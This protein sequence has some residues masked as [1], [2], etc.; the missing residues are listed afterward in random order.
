MSLRLDDCT[1]TGPAL[2]PQFVQFE[3]EKILV[4]RNLLPKTTGADGEQL[5]ARWESF[6]RKLRDLT[7]LGGSIRVQNHVIE[8][9]Q[10]RLGYSKI[11]R[12]PE[13]V[14]TSLK[15]PEDGGSVLVDDTTSTRLRF[16]S[17]EFESDIESP[18]RKNDAYRYS[19]LQVAK[20]VL[21]AAGQRYALLTN[22]IELRLV[23]DD[24]ARRESQ[25]I[26]DLDEWRKQRDVP[27]SYRLLIALVSPAG[28]KFLPDLIE[29][30]RLQQSRVTKELRLQARQA[31]EQFIQEVL[32][33]PENRAY[34]ERIEDKAEL[35]KKLW[36]EGLILVYRL[37]FILKS[38]SNDN[39]AKQFRFAASRIWR[40]TYSPAIALANWVTP[41]LNGEETGE[42][43]ETGLRQLF[44]MFVEGIES[45]ELNVKPLGGAL[46][47]ED[48]TP[49]LSHRKWGER[50][51]ALL[52]RNLM[53]APR[54]KS[55]DALQRVHYG[56][57]DVEE[58]GRVYEALLEL[59]P[60]IAQESMC[61]LRRQKLEVVV[62][63]AQGEKYRAVVAAVGTTDETDN[64]DE[65]AEDAEEETGSRKK[66]KVEW[67]EQIPAGQFYLRVGIGRKASGS[68]YTPH[69]FV[70]FLVKETLTPLIAERS[71][72]SDPHPAELLKL[73]ILDPAMGSGHFLVE[74]CRFLGTA[75]Y[76]AVRTCDERAARAE[77][78]AETRADRD[79]RDR[80]RQEVLEYRS[81]IEALPIDSD[82]LMQYLPS[83]SPT[84][85]ETDVAPKKAI[86][87][88]M[89]LVAVHCLYGVDVNPLAVELAK[90]ALWI[91]TQSEGL[92]LTFMD[93][94]LVVGNSL[95]GPFFE[96]LLTYP[97]NR[98]PIDDLF[99]QGLRD[100]LSH[101]LEH[102]LRLNHQLEA[103][104][105]FEEADNKAKQSV[106][107]ELEQELAPFL[108]LAA[109]WSGGVMLGE[110]GC[111][112]QAYVELVKEVAGS[113]AL[114]VRILPSDPIGKMLALG[115][116]VQAIPT[117]GSELAALI[118]AGNTIPAFSFDLHFA[119]VFYPDG[120]LAD[121]FG[122]DVVLGNP[123]WDKLLPNDK[124]FFAA[125]QF[126]IINA[127]TKRERKAIQD[128]LITHGEVAEVYQ[129]Y[130]F[131]FRS[132]EKIFAELYR[133]QVAVIDGEK[134][135]GKQD[136]F[137]LFMER[138]AQLLSPVGYVGLVVPS[139][140]HANEGATAIRQ[141]YIETMDLKKCFSFVNSRKLFEIH[142][143]FKFATVVAA[144]AGP[145]SSIECAFY[146]EDDKWLFDDSSPKLHYDLDFVRKTGGVYLSLLEIQDEYDARTI[147]D[148]Y[149]ESELF[150]TLIK[151]NSISLGRELNMTD[152][153]EKFIPS[154]M[155]L[156]D[157][158]DS[159]DKD[160]MEM[161]LEKGL[162]S[163][164]EGKSFW[165]YQDH[166]EERPNYLIEMAKIL[167]KPLWL[168]ASRYYRIAYRAIAS[169]TNERTVIFCLLP[170]G[171]VFG[172][173]APVERNPRE[174][175][176]STALL[177]CAL[178]NTFTFDWTARIR[179][180]ANVNQFILFSCPVPPFSSYESFAVHCALRLTCNH[181]GYAQLWREQVADAWHEMKSQLHF[182][183]LTTDDF[184]P[185]VVF[186]SSHLV[187]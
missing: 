40:E 67:I 160:T 142:S 47:G 121:Q 88:C 87:L 58:L 26:F 12:I 77:A 157:G 149:Q 2:P 7:S 55:S 178:A 28:L 183:V 181:V 184:Q 145:T 144:K 44:R 128:R 155:V 8:P 71:P 170:P 151:E 57:L 171:G 150:G 85:H 110:D 103:N 41:A 123:P 187:S 172:N 79:V 166:W 9:L 122:F 93:H 125:Y 68:Y 15:E 97:G 5:Q 51:V 19:H 111:D 167:H 141:L 64:E 22:G 153:A 124:E 60:G 92:P 169:S 130:I 154:T 127:N 117:S 147:Y 112:N 126:D 43:L 6:R 84:G 96:H 133:Y 86:A 70:R 156:T 16:W 49:I 63:I 25:I 32:Q 174:I 10:S 39:P 48:V 139:A 72:E 73:K 100:T 119:E 95:T 52:L 24:P 17:T 53:W 81:R 36:K 137:R 116:G 66:V 4:S 82:A 75:L 69:S 89:R 37:L 106:K 146:L 94:R 143:S 90:L 140:F 102:V 21:Y 38:E 180:G 78:I 105:G 99:A 132:Q 101:A 164:V 18:S 31:V 98:E 176:R 50:A 118:S 113:G 168:E 114:P 129:D 14:M 135:I 104:I 109:A 3:M 162:L 165:H 35:A 45:K 177:I 185:Q 29:Q 76:E 27:D 131:G 161:L 54:R 74:A 33:H 34:F 175:H 80:A 173:S 182:P 65:D 152:D 42:M 46:F 158:L 20:R 11:E 120:K 134:T 163:V 13:A 59:E 56:S 30:A 115:L 62:P 23:L 138:K 136:A 148:I 61:R 179:T 107:D 159:R 83:H 186:E 108:A 91:E 1:I